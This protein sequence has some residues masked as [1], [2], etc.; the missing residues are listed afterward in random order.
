MRS[1]ATRLLATM[2]A[3]AFVAAASFGRSEPATAAEDEDTIVIAIP[4]LPQGVDLDRHIGPQTWTMGAQL[5]A[6][7][8]EW[9]FG[10]YPYGT[11]K[12]FDPDKLPGY[13]YPIGYT[14][15]HTV[16]GIM[17][18]CETAEDGKTVTMHIRPG[19]MSAYGNEFTADDVIWRIERERKNPVIYFLINRLLNLHEADWKKI[20]KYTVQ[21]TNATPMPLGCPGL[22]NYYQSW[23]DSKAVEAHKTAD[24]PNADNWIATH[25]G[26]FGAYQ[27]TEWTPGKRVVMEAN[28]NFWRG[29]PKIKKI[30]YLVVPE[31]AGRLALLQKGR[32][33]MA[34]D[35]SPDEVMALEGSDVAEGVAVRGNR[36]MWLTL[37]NEMKPFDDVRV[38]QAINYSIPREQIV[39]NVYRGMAVP[40]NGVI[41]SVTP[42]YENL[43]PYGFD[44]DKA[45]ALLA[46]AGYENGFTADLAFSAGVPEMEN[47]ALIL[48]S[49]L[50]KLGINLNLKKLPVAAH[51]DLVQ[52]RKAQMA[53]WIDSPIQPDV[54]Y[55]VNLVYTSGPLSLVNYSN[56]NDP[57]VDRIIETGAGILDPQERLEHHKGVQQR[58]QEKAAF[59]W[60][61]EPY[62][63]IGVSKRLKNW[64]WYTTQYYQVHEMEIIK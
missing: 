35:L 20:D 55:V 57:E 39:D 63:R 10:P 11:G 45:K 15:Q 24:D 21:L 48:Q 28:E 50:S 16:G 41:S 5:Y 51:S 36:Q 9:E 42:G 43:K 30:I 22:T 6:L 14:N 44:L 25:G 27:V 56:F 61:V 34:E 13:A 49:T 60:S 46:E 7:G 26:G 40:W 33:D 37:N 47:L 3:I 23:H 29:P 4:G 32:V 58:I 8:L 59:G 19:V 53:L 1:V 31:S 52:T 54:N 18:S 17:E 12:Y 38:R 62:F 64:R 2:A